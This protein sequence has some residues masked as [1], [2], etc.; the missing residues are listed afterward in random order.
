MEKQLDTIYGEMLAAFGKASGYLPNPSC[1][2]AARLY[3]AA[4]QIQGL[5]HQAQWVLDQSFPQTAQ[6]KY[7]EQHALLR[8]IT[9]SVATCAGGTLRFGISS[10][11]ASDLTIDSGTVCMTETGIR[12]ATTASVI[13]HAGALYADAPAVALEPGKA[14]NVAPNTITLMAAMPVGVRA[15]TNPEAFRGGDDAE[16][17]LSLRQRLLDSY[18]RLPNGAN[19]AYYEQVALSF[20]GV[21]AAVAVGRP[22]GVGSVDV[23]VATDGGLPDE[24][25]LTE[26]NAF[27]QERREISVDLRVIAPTPVPVAVTVAVKPAAGSTFAEAKADVEAALR[28]YFTGALLSRGVTLASLGELLYHL[29]S[30]ENYRF[31]AP[32]ADLPPAATSLPSLGA[33]TVTEMGA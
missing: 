13:L 23:Y 22:R 32:A 21:A 19:A 29:D 16:S 26:L 30:V 4:A 14:G 3:A 7:L 27:L 25:L 12:F 31:A 2:L 28:G 8:G 17:D 10:A 6:G 24:T 18:R 9:R 20:N 15:C 33:V 5:Y 11:L 1:D